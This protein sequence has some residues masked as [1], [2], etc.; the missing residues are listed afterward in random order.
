MYRRAAGTGDGDA[1]YRLGDLLSQREDPDAERYYRQAAEAGHFRASFEL[2][3]IFCVRGEFADAESFYRLSASAGSA[4]SRNNLANMLAARGALAE[5]EN[6][7]REAAEA[8]HIEAAFN[9]SAVLAQ[10]R[11]RAPGGR[12]VSSGGP[13][14]RSHGHDRPSGPPRGT[15]RSISLGAVVPYCRRRWPCWRVGRPSGPVGHTPRME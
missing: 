11:W 1:A 6:L 12:S 7:Y 9:L 14:V 15:G 3:N 5:A 8:G 4:E 13:A 2:A 10:T